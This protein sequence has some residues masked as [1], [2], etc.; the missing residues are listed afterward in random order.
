MS[1]MQSSSNT[2]GLVWTETGAPRRTRSP[3]GRTNLTEVVAE[4]RA[5]G[6]RALANPRAVGASPGMHRPMRRTQAQIRSLPFAKAGG[7]WYVTRG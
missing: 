4:A 6:A 5:A 3:V 7:Q 2:P 1:A